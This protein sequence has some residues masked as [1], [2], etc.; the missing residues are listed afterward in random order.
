MKKSLTS[1][2]LFLIVAGVVSYYFTEI[3]FYLNEEYKPAALSSLLEGTAARPFQYRALVP[4]IVSAISKTGLHVPA[5]HLPPQLWITNAL[6]IDHA[7]SFVLIEL[8]SVFFLVVA[9]R[10]YISMFLKNNTLSTVL[11]FTLFL[12]LPFNYVLP[13]AAPFWYPYDMPA[14]LFFTLGLIFLYRQK[15]AMYYTVFLI[16]VFNRETIC[17]LTFVYL[18]TSIGERKPK[19]ILLHC[20]LQFVLWLAIKYF[21][22]QLYSSNPGEGLF[23]TQLLANI[24]FLLTPKRYP[25]FLSNMGF[26]LIPIVFYFRLI[27]NDFV[28]RSLFVGIP[29]FLAMMYVADIWELRIYGELLPIMLL[30][31]LIILEKLMGTESGGG[32]ETQHSSYLRSNYCP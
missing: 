16:G 27:D 31:F 4:W 5:I 7:R 8:I 29:F 13:R 18:I 26:I 28:R 20:G 22:Y 2:I 9:F 25:F 32:V 15:W 17:F 10:Y 6:S 19:V 21:L 23:E 11:A 3:R 24:G 1:Q 14:I 12:V 30:A